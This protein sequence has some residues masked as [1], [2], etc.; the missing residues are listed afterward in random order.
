MRLNRYLAECGL[1]S[2]RGVEQLIRDGR[3]AV[4]GETVHELGTRV[5]DGQVVVVDGKPVRP[6]TSQRLY[7]YNKPMGVVSSFARQGKARCL[8][9]VLPKDILDGRLFHV[10]RLDRESTGLLLLGSDGD[11]AQALLHPKHPV[12]K[13]YRVRCELE[14]DDE[15]LREIREGELELDG[16]PLAPA[17]IEFRGE[18]G[19]SFEYEIALR[20]GRNRQIRRMLELLNVRVLSLHRFAFGP[21]T[22]GGLE[23]GA[24]RPATEDEQKALAR[25]AGLTP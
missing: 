8:L 5:E 20:E 12:W 15:D 11:L 13:R 9:D 10:G 1:G 6:A 2:R 22:L 16:T 24:L 21:V 3:V 17:E 14:L 25:A 23:V 4:D 19:G 7:V 18:R